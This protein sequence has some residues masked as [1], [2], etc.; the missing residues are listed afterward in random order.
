M[1]RR[2]GMQAAVVTKPTPG[3]I[4]SKGTEKI[5]VRIDLHKKFL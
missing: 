5:F 3:F 1:K 4:K 2:S